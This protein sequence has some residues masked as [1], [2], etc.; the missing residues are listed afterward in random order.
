[1]SF[2]K[3]SLR[4][5][6]CILMGVALV[7][8]LLFTG[9]YAFSKSRHVVRNL[10]LDKMIAQADQAASMVRS[11]IGSTRANTLNTPEFPP[12]PGIIRCWDNMESPG[13]DP[14]QVGSTT[15]D[16]INRLD[17][18]LRSQMKWHHERK[19]CAFYKA[20]GEGVLQVMRLGADRYELAVE[21]IPNAANR[22]FFLA[23]QQIAPGE[24]HISPMRKEGDQ[25]VVRCCTPVYD[26]DA[27]GQPGKLRG[28][29]V[30]ALDGKVILDRMLQEILDA[31]TGRHSW[32]DVV[33]ESGQYLFSNDASSRVQTFSN[34]RFETAKP[35]R[36]EALQRR[37]PSGEYD[38]EFDLYKQYI[39]GSERPD[40][41]PLIATYRRVYYAGPEDRSRFWAISASEHAETA[42]ESVTE[43]GRGFWLVG[44]LVALVAGVF[45]YY[46][47]GRLTASLRT[48]ARAA[49]SI[50]RGDLEEE[51]PEIRGL[52]EITKLDNSFRSMT[53]NLRDTIERISHHEARTQAIL[54]STA[55]AIVTI[56]QSGTVLSCNLPTERI[57]GIE[58]GNIIGKK[59]SLLCPALYDDEAQ[60]DDQGLAAGEMKILGSEIEVTGHRGNGTKFPVALRVAEMNH[61]GDKLFIATMRDIT[62]RKQG[63]QE[64][65]RLFEAIRDAVRR[66]ASATQQILATTSQQAAG[67]QQ[68]ASAVTETAS[69]A[70]EMS[71]SAR[72]SAN[73]AN[74]L[75]G[76]SQQTGATGIEGRQHIEDAIAAMGEVKQQVQVLAESIVSLAEQAQTIGEI[77]A[78][79]NDIAEQTNVLA[80]NAAVEASRAGEHGKGFGVVAS[81]V[82]SLAD[83][84]KKAT[85]QVRKILGEIQHASNKAVLSTEHG[86]RAVSD[87]GEIVKRAGDTITSLAD[88]LTT[89][90]RTA[91][92][93]SAAINQQAAGVSQ[94]N[95]GIRNIDKV[96]EENVKAIQQI[97]ASA[98]NLN[99]LSN[100]LAGLVST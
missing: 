46:A 38:A 13:Q 81:E 97:E 5:Q 92:Q 1:M 22:D 94:L 21:N 14:V 99:A 79:V 95:I 66:L 52:G 85:A 82:K 26:R 3:L 84:S 25:V 12:I 57:F 73:R 60:Y 64:R 69:T 89:T 93:I 41:V 9:W 31:E 50:A 75:A 70:A 56:D 36:A 74:E 76:T 67:A 87:A 17:Q 29:F 72:E 2:T 49:D 47:A 90:A 91:S 10:T 45:S 83:Q 63:E 30:I 58:C 65:D 23:T 39:P 54:D 80:L 18:I 27:T 6:I 8:S 43:L 78:T 37:Q 100:E 77:T 42:L 34:D 35:A 98:R 19:W 11:I 59:A 68:Q 24:V 61:A 88:T 4:W 20:N 33:D 86:T 40:G 71:E 96:T 16:W 7:L 53:A 32:I 55:D 44:L 51:L 28:V 62:D 15:E 48:L